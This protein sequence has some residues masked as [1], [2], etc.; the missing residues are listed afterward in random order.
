M[1]TTTEIDNRGLGPPEPMVRILSGLQQ[2]E[3][4]GQLVALMDREPLLLY[5]ELERRG[6]EW[7]FE[8]L[9]DHYRLTI[10]KATEA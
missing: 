6:W 5:P 4:G 2:L 8:E 3:D 1:A 7:S 10:W 9:D